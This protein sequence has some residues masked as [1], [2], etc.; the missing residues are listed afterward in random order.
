MSF[1]LVLFCQHSTIRFAVH[2][3]EIAPLIEPVKRW[4]IEVLEFVGRD[5]RRQLT[6]VPAIDNP[7]QLRLLIRSIRLSLD[8]QL[9]QLV[10][11]EEWRGTSLL[12]D[13]V[14]ALKIS[15]IERIEKPLGCRIETRY[16]PLPGASCPVQRYQ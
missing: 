2:L 6:L 3:H 13:L 8:I 1:P 14:F 11:H 10:K 15:G 5:D 12:N 9:A 4:L 7:E 16:G